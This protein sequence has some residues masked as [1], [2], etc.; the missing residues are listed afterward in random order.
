[1]AARVSVLAAW[2]YMSDVHD[3]RDRSRS[4]VDV[5]LCLE[6]SEECSELVAADVL[7]DWRHWVMGSA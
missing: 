5:L 7:A 6:G 4:R 1:M 3:C 2:L